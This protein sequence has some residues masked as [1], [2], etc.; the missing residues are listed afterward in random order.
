MH[1]LGCGRIEL[2]VKH[3]ASSADVL[4]V[5][6]LDHAA[7]AHGILVLQLAVQHVTE[8]LGVTMRVLAE[9]LTRLHDVVVD[10]AQ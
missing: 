4:Q 6:R 1:R 3:A 7:V 9:A 10:H 8:D 5:A 2:A